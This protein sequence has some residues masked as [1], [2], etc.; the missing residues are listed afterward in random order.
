MIDSDM[1]RHSRLDAAGVLQHVIVR[2]IERRRIFSD[3]S[4][5]NDFLDRIGAVF[6]A[7]KAICYAFALLPNHAHLL[8]RT[9]DA[10]LSTVMSRLLTGY[11]VH[12]NRRHRRH[13]QLFQNRYKSIVCQED[14]YF[15]ELI[16]YIHLNPLRAGIVKDLEALATF[17]YCGHA[18]LMGK[19]KLPWYGAESILALFSAKGARTAYLDFV[20]AGVEQ[21][22]RSDLSGGGLMRSHGEWA[23]IRRSS[24]RLKGDARILGDSQFVLDVLSSA[25]QRPDHRYK[26]KA[27]GV[28]YSFVEH[29]VLQLCG[30]SRDE[31]YSRSR[32][33]RSAEAKGLLCFWAVRE[34]G[35][36]QTQL[37]ER[38][39]MT[40]P[41]AASAV[42]RG[43][44]LVRERGHLLLDEAEQR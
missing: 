14:A 21:G 23:E 20:R 5:R 36:S 22:R 15:K 7:T 37:S 27:M 38:L 29:R 13:G 44:R 16:R 12:F 4:D 2:G 1:A 18:V 33:R 39:G 8:L 31:L 17:P 34:L 32:R 35:M 43:E 11:V 25:Q 10:P 40:Q 3:D 30:L 42:A 9:G 41:G 24:Q 28:D 26:L 6:P 19:A